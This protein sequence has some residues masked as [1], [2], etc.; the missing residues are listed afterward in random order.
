MSDTN[1]LNNSTWEGVSLSCFPVEEANIQRG[2]ITCPRSHSLETVELGFKSVP[3]P[4][5]IVLIIVCVYRLPSHLELPEQ[6]KAV[7][8][9]SVATW[10]LYYPITFQCRAQ[11]WNHKTYHS[12]EEAN[13][14][15]T[16]IS[17][18]LVDLK[19]ISCTSL[20]KTIP[21]VPSTISWKSAQMFW[22]DITRTLFMKRYMILCDANF[23]HLSKHAH[24]LTLLM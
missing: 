22:Y 10:R 23:L 16:S 1:S 9:G 12:Q 3:P 6:E 7:L 5:S 21:N 4:K 11:N 14:S 13:Q 18:A 2:T 8:Q 19:R 20:S 17:A 15:C 24:N